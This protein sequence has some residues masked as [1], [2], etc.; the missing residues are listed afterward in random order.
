MDRGEWEVDQRTERFS[1]EFLGA[2]YFVSFPLT[3][4]F[5]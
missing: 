2:A 5:P 1:E 4:P 3:P